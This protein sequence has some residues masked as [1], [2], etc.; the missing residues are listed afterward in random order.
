M[1]LEVVDK[2]LPQLIRRARIIEV[3]SFKLKILFEGWPE[4]Y[5]YWVED[6]SPDIHPI[7]WCQAT[8]HPIEITTSK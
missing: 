3:K 2:K 5:A 6:D 1:R 8:K 7:G 4:D